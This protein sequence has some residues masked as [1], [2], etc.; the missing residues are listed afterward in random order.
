METNFI[1]LDAARIGREMEEAFLLNPVHDCLYTGKS[2]DDL[3][4]VAPYIFDLAQQGDLRN[5]FGEKGWGRAW[6]ILIGCKAGFEE[7]REHFRKFLLARTED[8][9]EFYFRFYDPRVLKNFLPSC[10]QLQLL[11]FFGP[12]SYF[13]VEGEDKGCAIRYWQKGG[14]L[15]QETIPATAG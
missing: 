6:G 15:H 4:G 12:V 9:E 8:G 10:D 11:E 1:L 14:T 2:R 3:G 13:I 7:C 5:W